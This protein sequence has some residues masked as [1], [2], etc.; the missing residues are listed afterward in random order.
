MSESALADG[1][2]EHPLPKFTEDTLWEDWEPRGVLFGKVPIEIE[3][4]AS[5]GAA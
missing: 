2:G 1:K 5:A 4:V 3:S